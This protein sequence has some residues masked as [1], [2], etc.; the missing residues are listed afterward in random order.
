MA[1][2]K[3]VVIRRLIFLLGELILALCTVWGG[4][5]I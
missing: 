2:K 5:N 3:R 4:E 1:E